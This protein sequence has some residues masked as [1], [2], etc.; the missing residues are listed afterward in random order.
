MRLT[1]KLISLGAVLSLLLAACNL[2]KATPNA[3]ATMQA[4]YTSQ[5]I[6]AATLQAQSGA[7]ATPGTLPTI[8]FPTLPATATAFHH[9]L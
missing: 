9:L 7:T 8:T 4:V 1:I 2:P 5:A 6:M 3:A